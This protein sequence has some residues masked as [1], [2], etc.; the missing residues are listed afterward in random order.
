[1]SVFNQSTEI[2]KAETKLEAYSYWAEGHLEDTICPP[3]QSHWPIGYTQMKFKIVSYIQHIN[4][5]SL[6]PDPTCNTLMV[7]VLKRFIHGTN[8]LN[9]YYCIYSNTY[10]VWLTRIQMSL[11]VQN[12][13]HH[14]YNFINSPT[15]TLC[16]SLYYMSNP[17]NLLAK[18]YLT[19]YKII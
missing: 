13:Q 10:R 11:S 6:L 2:L 12:S 18:H 1:M 4:E 9:P 3:C 8:I 16:S 14:N 19:L 17:P 15:C 5:W 7:N